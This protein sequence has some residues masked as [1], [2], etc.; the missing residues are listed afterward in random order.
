M[1]RYNTAST[2][3]RSADRA[4]QVPAEVETS[5]PARAASFQSDVLVPMCQAGVTGGLL[6]A[7]VTAAALILA[8]GL[9]AHPVALWA[10]AT[11]AIVTVAWLALLVDHRRLLWAV[12]RLINA[13]LDQDGATGEPAE[14]LVIVNAEASHRQAAEVANAQRRSLFE[15][16]VMG[17]GA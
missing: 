14:R 12:E 7:V 3:P 17:L 2:W 8:P 13:D 11:L 9:D 15:I 5:T 1:R 4:Q 10:G 6:G 16:F